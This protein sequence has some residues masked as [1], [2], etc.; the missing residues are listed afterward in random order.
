MLVG[1][2]HR[3]RSSWREMPKVQG[4]GFARKQVYGDRVAAEGVDYQQIEV[5]RLFSFER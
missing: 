5:L 1:D 2:V 3:E 4:E